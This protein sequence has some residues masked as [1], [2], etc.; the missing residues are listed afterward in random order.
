[1]FAVEPDVKTDVRWE[2]E[3]IATSVSYWGSI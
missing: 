1:V 2:R 3:L